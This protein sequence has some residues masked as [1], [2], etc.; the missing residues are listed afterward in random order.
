M[1]YIV[2]DGLSGFLQ[3][4][5]RN[6]SI[7]FSSTGIYPESPKALAAMILLCDELKANIIKAH[8]DLPQ[9]QKTSTCSN[10]MKT[11]TFFALYKE[12]SAS[13]NIRT[14]TTKLFSISESHDGRVEFEFKD[15]SI[16]NA[17]A[18][19]RSSYQCQITHIKISTL[20]SDCGTNVKVA[21]LM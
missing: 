14:H 1:K 15:M 18:F 20:H 12:V 3:L 13:G 21:K 6:G 19:V 2:T 8:S 9:I 4:D 10:G 17:S 11:T 5:F 7:K 16:K